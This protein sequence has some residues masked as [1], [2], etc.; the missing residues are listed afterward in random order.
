[1]VQ[2]A[3]EVTG[4]GGGRDM[5]DLLPKNG[6]MGGIKYLVDMV[7]ALDVLWLRVTI[8]CHAANGS[9]WVRSMTCNYAVLIAKETGRT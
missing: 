1:V 4:V 7:M 8:K 5:A 2:V 6:N 9:G 3:N